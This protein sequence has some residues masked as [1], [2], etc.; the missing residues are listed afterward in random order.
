MLRIDDIHFAM[1][2]RPLFEGA[3]AQIP[4]GHKVGLVGRNGAGKTTLFR[5]IRGELALE[6]G[7]IALP[8]RA[9]IGGVAQE[10]PGSEVSLIDT[11]LAADTERAEL[12]AEAESATDGTR[13]A[14]VQT[15]LADIDAWSAEARAAAILKGLGFSDAEQQMPCSAFSGGWRMRVALAA[16]LFSAPDLLLLDEPTNYLDLEGALWLEQYLARYPHTVLI[17]SHDRGLLNRAVGNILHLEDRKLTYYAVPYDQFAERRAERLAQAQAENAKAQARIAH[18]QSFVDRFRYKASKAVQAQ[19]RLKMIERIQLVSTPQEA[20]LKKFTFPE[21]E[22]LSPPIINLEN[23]ATGYG[24][25]R[26]LSRMTLRIDQDDRIALLGRNGQ[27]KSTLAKLLSD[28]LSLQDGTMTKARK[29][30]IGYFA[31]HQV[32]EL[33]VNETPLEHLRR[34]LPGELPGKHRARLGGF[35]LAAAQAETEVG[36][37]SGGQKAR[38]SLMLATLDAPHLLIL[39]E[40]TN[41]LDIESREALVEALTAYTGAVILVSHDMHLLSLVADRLWLVKDGR[42]TPYEEDL[43]AYRRMLLSADRPAEKPKPEKPKPVSREKVLELRAE[44]RKCEARLEKLNEMRD[45]LATKLADPALYEPENLGQME[46]WQKKYA[47]VM[48]GLD[49]AEGLWLTAQEKL[50]AAEAR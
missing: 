10:V 29:L 44:V 5:L 22:E 14:E 38:L 32:D 33:R 47:E 39:D 45:K 42:V 28:R 11:V 49:R 13:I 23:A 19:S 43:E 24:E 36:R 34:L 4:T 50:E 15:R 35:G 7:A 12:M 9:R 18:L 8:P 46:V 27:G 30:R 41:H 17:I 6:S 37:L 40:P 3:S 16:V 26:V 2:G 25:R 31:Q 20:A 48:D 1:E 21:P